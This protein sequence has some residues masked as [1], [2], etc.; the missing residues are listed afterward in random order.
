MN[1][2]NQFHFTESSTLVERNDVNIIS[3]HDVTTAENIG[4]IINVNIEFTQ[5]VY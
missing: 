5:D 3:K 4:F 2:R 1:T